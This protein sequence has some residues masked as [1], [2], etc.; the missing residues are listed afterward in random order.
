MASWLGVEPAS[1]VV[2]LVHSLVR[3]FRAY[4]PVGSDWGTGR[5]RERERGGGGGKTR[6][7]W[8]NG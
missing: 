5:E 6:L 8:L 4:G 7:E 3:A 1:E 2:F